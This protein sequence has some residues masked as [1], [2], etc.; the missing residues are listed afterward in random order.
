MLNYFPKFITRGAITLYF[1]SL[2]AMFVGFT[3][4]TMRPLWI[5]FGIAQVIG[6]FYFANILSKRWANYSP[7]LFEKK[8]LYT[9]LAL[10]LAWVIFSY[11]LYQKMTG[12][13]FEF[14]AADAIAYDAMG[15]DGAFHF[16]NGYFNVFQIFEYMGISDTGYASYL[17]LVYWITDNS[18]LFARIL[19]AIWATLMCILVY[20][21]AVRNFGEKIG[22]IAAIICMLFPNFI[23]YCGLHLKETEMIFLTVLFL[24]RADHLLRSR[25]FSF[26]SISLTLLI[27]ALLFTFRTVLGAVAILSVIS[28]IVFT[29]E[30]VSRWGRRI[31]VGFLLALVIAFFAG[32]KIANDI[33]D[34]WETR[35][36]NQQVGLEW[37][38]N[39]EGGNELVRYASKSIFLPAIFIIPFPTMVNIETQQNQQLIHGG[40]AIKDILSFFLLLA[41][42]LIVFQQQRWKDFTLLEAFLVGYLTVIALSNFAQSERFHLPAMPVYMMFV[43]YG[44]AHVDVRNK[45]YFQPYLVLLFLIFIAWN[46]FK[47]RGRGLV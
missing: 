9:A 47:L 3:Q 7:K 4:Y 6:F 12:V 31:L 28:A 29:S 11:F 41:I 43:A 22:R 16:S 21:L 18:I 30:R 14:D 40:Y 17:S 46:Y 32:G 36:E 8:L 39:R 37:R 35:E 23:Y 34:L 44:I 27:A 10:R 25:D 13:P 20:R 45:K 2:L 15:K 1:I 5:V 33:S 19:K 42:F 24:E 26:K 38:A